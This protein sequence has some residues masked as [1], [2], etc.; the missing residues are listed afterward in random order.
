MTNPEAP[1]PCPA[2]DDDMIPVRRGL[3]GAVNFILKRSG[4]AGSATAKEFIPLA[5]SHPAPSTDVAKI[6]AWLR[7]GW[8]DGSLPDRFADAIE[9]GDWK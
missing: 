2:R 7:K 1:A 9:R 6:V 3:I 5:M 4:H 8:S